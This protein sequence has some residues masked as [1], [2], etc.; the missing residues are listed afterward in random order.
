MK[1]EIIKLET[2]RIDLPNLIQKLSSYNIMILYPQE[3]IFDSSNIKNITYNETN[4]SGRW[5]EAANIVISALQ[6]DEL[7]RLKGFEEYSHIKIDDDL[8][9]Y[10]IKWSNRL[11][12]YNFLHEH[13]I[14]EIILAYSRLHKLHN[15]LNKIGT[16]KPGLR[17]KYY[18]LDDN[19][20]YIFMYNYTYRYDFYLDK[21]RE[22]KSYITMKFQDNNILLGIM[23]YVNNDEF[24]LAFVAKNDPKE[25]KQ[26]PIIYDV[27]DITLYNRTDV[28]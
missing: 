12:G 8:T 21:S 18:D 17:I 4:F 16:V 5:I 22:V 14:N 26:N 6:Q 1:H 11:A 25:I 19:I 15:D 13:H 24:K 27:I 3:I 10:G 23:E 9:I 20:K 2:R 7:K 28:N